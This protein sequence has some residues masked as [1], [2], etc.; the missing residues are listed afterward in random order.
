MGFLRLLLSPFRGAAWLYVV[1]FLFFFAVG[2]VALLFGFSLGD[3]DNWLD[4]N[5]GWIE[6]IGDLL[7]RLFFAFVLLMSAAIALMCIY[8]GID[9]VWRRGGRPTPA[10][11]NKKEEPGCLG[12]GCGTIAAALVGYFAWFGVF[13]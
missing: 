1:L 4:A 9:R 8:Q 3:V 10:P 2:A 11:T 12:L 6:A 5:G 13:Y 7:F